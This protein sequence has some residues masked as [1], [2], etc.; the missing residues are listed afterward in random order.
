MI[1]CPTG[2]IHRDLEEGLVII[3]DRTCIGCRRCENNCPYD[4]IRMV[5]VR[6]EQCLPILDSTTHAPI[7]KATKCDLCADQMKSVSPACQLACPHD[8]L[9]RVDM[10]DIDAVADWLNR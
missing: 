4:A 7:E 5:E 8:A 3:N 2:A 1:D 6:D 9:Q 10:T